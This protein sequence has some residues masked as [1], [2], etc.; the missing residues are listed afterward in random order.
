MRKDTRPS[1]SFVQPNMGTRAMERGYYHT[2]IK[3]W[4]IV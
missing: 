4:H 2:R 1:A 3:L